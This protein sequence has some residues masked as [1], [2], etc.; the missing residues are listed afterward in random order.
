MPKKTYTISCSTSY[1]CNDLLGLVCPNTTGVCNCPFLSSSIFCDCKRDFNN[2]YYW[3]GQKCQTAKQIGQPCDNATTGYMCQTITQ[4]IVC[5]V[6]SGT[7]YSCQCP[8]LQ[9]FDILSNKCKNQLL[10]NQSCN[11]TR[12]DMCLNVLGLSCLLGT[13]R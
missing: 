11:S 9:Y 7:T 2:E 8:S 5:S 1:Q 13:C 3:D 4:G 12:S 6:S 10:I